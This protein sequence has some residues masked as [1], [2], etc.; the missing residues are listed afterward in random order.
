M[1][2]W[3]EEKGITDR[4]KRARMAESFEGPLSKQAA[5]AVEHSQTTMK[6][7]M[8]QCAIHVLARLS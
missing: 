4:A 5:R 7:L 2:Q 6:D 3:L 1:D 8:N